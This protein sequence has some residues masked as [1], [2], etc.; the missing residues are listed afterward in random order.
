MD[1]HESSTKTD[2]FSL[3]QRLAF[4]CVWTAVIHRTGVPAPAHAR[5]PLLEVMK[6]GCQ[7][8]FAAYTMDI[9]QSVHQ[10][11]VK[12]TGDVIWLQTSEGTWM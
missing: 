9:Y 5:L 6:G 4:P 10:G 1:S 2:F 7:W 11:W 3:H 12:T 8:E